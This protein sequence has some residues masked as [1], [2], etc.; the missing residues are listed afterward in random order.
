M[1][2][3]TPHHVF[4][5]KGV[6]VVFV[7]QLTHLRKLDLFVVRVQHELKHVSY[8][9]DIPN[10]LDGPSDAKRTIEYDDGVIFRITKQVGIIGGVP[11]I[12]RDVF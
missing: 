9:M 4:H 3:K 11:G 6:G 12:V 10:F 5:R 8:A 7:S 1:F 2:T